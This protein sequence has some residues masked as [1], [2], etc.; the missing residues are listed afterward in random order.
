MAC[1][2]KSYSLRPASNTSH[3]MSTLAAREAATIIMSVAHAF[4]LLCSLDCLC[5]HASTWLYKA[6]DGRWLLVASRQPAGQPASLLT[7]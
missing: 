4:F 5:A 2:L 1:V 7:L 6:T 3:A